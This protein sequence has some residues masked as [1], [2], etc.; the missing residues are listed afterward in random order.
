MIPGTFNPLLRKKPKIFINPHGQFTSYV[1]SGFLTD[2]AIAD[3]DAEDQTHA[4]SMAY[5][6]ARRVFCHWDGNTNGIQALQKSWAMQGRS[7]RGNDNSGPPYVNFHMSI[8]YYSSANDVYNNIESTTKEAVGLQWG[9]GGSYTG[10]VRGTTGSTLWSSALGSSYG[11]INTSFRITY[12]R[13]TDTVKFWGRTDGSF[14]SMVELG[15]YTF[16]SGNRSAM[17]HPNAL[18]SIGGG[19]RGNNDGVYDW[20]WYET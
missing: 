12:D 10:Y 9:N 11:A 17:N 13:D 4:S 7:H 16:T 3:G 18:F 2:D 1:T 6:G 5:N 19:M 15:S 14:D 20:S 8:G